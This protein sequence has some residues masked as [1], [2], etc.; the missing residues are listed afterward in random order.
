L[1]KVPTTIIQAILHDKL[2][3]DSCVCLRYPS[4]AL[5]KRAKR[6]RW[7]STAMPILLVLRGASFKGASYRNSKMITALLASEIR[8]H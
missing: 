4:E 2:A 7:L 6:K 3:C 8:N 5:N 1:P